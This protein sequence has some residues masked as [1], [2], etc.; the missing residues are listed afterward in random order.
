MSKGLDTQNAMRIRGDIAANLHRVVAD[1]LHANSQ[2]K[3]QVQIKKP[4]YIYGETVHTFFVAKT[5]SISVGEECSQQKPWLHLKLC[6]CQKV[7]AYTV[8]TVL[9]FP[10][11]NDNGR[12]INRPY[13]LVPFSMGQAR[14]DVQR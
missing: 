10:L 11:Y 6:L 3:L 13:S 1:T 9:S 12:S 4:L 5:C 8:H 2:R 14:Y 7:F